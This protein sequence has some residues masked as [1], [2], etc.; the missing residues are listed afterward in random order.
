MTIAAANYLDV[1]TV[2]IGNA[3]L[4]VNTEEKFYTHA[5]PDFEVVG[6]TAEGYLLELI[7]ALYGLPTSRNRW[8]AHLSHTL[9]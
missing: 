2:D 9:R 4:N 6:I 1:M 5:R 8:H 7:Q 3:Y